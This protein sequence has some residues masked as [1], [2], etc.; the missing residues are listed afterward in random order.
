M[1][2]KISLTEDSSNKLIY[3]TIFINPI[4]LAPQ[5]PEIYINLTWHRTE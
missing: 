5:S 1:K 2:E 3:D 4:L